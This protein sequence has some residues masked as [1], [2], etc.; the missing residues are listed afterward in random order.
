[1]PWVFLV[2]YCSLLI[3]DFFFPC[4]RFF[5]FQ[6]VII[7]MRAMLNNAIKGDYNAENDPSVRRAVES[8]LG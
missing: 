8:T 2:V 1:M 6:N 7:D 3:L 5:F 4:F